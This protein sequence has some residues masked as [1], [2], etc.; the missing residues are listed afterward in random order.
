[1]FD[2][3]T[4][5]NQLTQSNVGM[6]RLNIMVGAKNFVQSQ[7][8]NFVSF[9]FI[10]IAENKSNYLKIT[11]AADD[12]YTVE[13]GYVR[14]MTYKVIKD[15]TGVYGENLKSLFESETKLYLSL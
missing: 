14:G 6:S 7:E 5:L 1:M 10:R 13:F 12:T 9:K 4:T 15:Y 3:K 2:A 8:E 11:L